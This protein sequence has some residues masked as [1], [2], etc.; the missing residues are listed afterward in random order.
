MGEEELIQM[1]RK[2]GCKLEKL[3]FLSL[4]PPLGGYPRQEVFWQPVIDRVHKKLDR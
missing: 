1:A 4:G 2:L 3:P